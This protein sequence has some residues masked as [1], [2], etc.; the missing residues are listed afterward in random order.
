MRFALSYCHLFAA[1]IYVILG[2]MII[3][4]D[5][6]SRLNH[7]CAGIFACLFLWSF[8]YT[9]IHH[10]DVSISAVEFFERLAAPG[11]MLFSFFHLWFI[12][13]YSR[14]KP[15]RFFKITAVGTMFVP[16]LLMYQQ[17]ANNA[18]ISRHERSVFGWISPWTPS[19]W[20][21]IFFI[22]YSATVLVGLF[23]LFGHRKRTENAAIKKQTTILIISAVAS[24]TIGS[25][26]DIVLPLV[27][28]RPIFSAGDIAA[29]I[30]AV[31]LAYVVAK[32]RLLDISAINA[33]QRIISAMKDLLFLL[34]TH[35]RI[36]LVNHSTL[37]T[38]GCSNDRL[39]GT[40]FM[41]I[42]SATDTQRDNLAS[43]IVTLTASTNETALALG[44]MPPIPVLLSTSLI[45]GTGIVCVAHDMSLQKQRTHLLSEEK[46]RL[47][48]EVAL[49]TGEL[50]KT[51]EQ[52]LREI[53][54]RKQAAMSLMETEERFR[55]IYENAPDGIFLMDPE[56]NFIDGNRQSHTILGFAETG[57]KGKN[58]FS[59]GVLARPGAVP[60]ARDEA[61]PQKGLAFPWAHETTLVGKDGVAVPVEIKTHPIKIGDKNLVLGVVR[62]LTI[63]K[64]AEAEAEELKRELHQAQ[65]MEAIGRLAG[66]IAHDFN[67]LLTGITGYS[68]LLV[69]KLMH[70]HPADTLVVQ[71][72]IDIARQATN[73]T[74]QLLAFARKGKYQVTP[75]NMHDV[76]D[77][78]TGLLEHI[79]DRTI[80]VK[81]NCLAPSSTVMGDR[82]QLHSAIL[83]IA[84][85]ARDA[86][87][88]GGEISF[89][90]DVVH[91]DN[92]LAHSYPYMI[93]PGD[94]LKMTIADNGIGMDEKVRSRVFEPFF[95][96]K[97]PGKGTGLGLASVYGTVK[98]HNGFIELW[99]EPG[100]GAIFTLFLPLSNE[101]AVRRETVEP[102]AAPSGPRRGNI[103]LV[104]D[105]QMI[106]EIASDVLKEL[107][108]TVNTCCDGG[109]ALSW[110]RQFHE[111]CDLV[112]L[113]L[114]MPKLSGKEC[115]R[116]MRSI[117]PSCK[118]IIMSGHAMDSEISEL[119]KEGAIAFLQK[120]FENERLVQTVDMVLAAPRQKA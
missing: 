58:A 46:K 83:N 60:A 15:F 34:D 84:V 116:A 41:E 110:F 75:V 20:T 32:Y 100:K 33:A 1:V 67:N 51:N 90:T 117:Q 108:Y 118:T 104:D 23:L 80:S 38:L 114:T 54:D 85:N 52:L 99:S 8:S 10:P 87:P 120:P 61:S 94:F 12:W 19:I 44:A 35:G 64:K 27:M 30:W 92:K 72:I 40:P 96:T 70:S 55:L 26:I 21:T 16:L 47:E 56:G 36:M 62:D 65:K 57:L 18:L 115:F 107:G 48:S 73:R 91:I 109:E 78:V 6:R 98:H 25:T 88:D 111:Q 9:W 13:L 112:I 45:P 89:S 97:E 7:V 22:Y 103:L 3:A 74:S 68:G 5:P 4:K 102:A 43:A 86:L 59:L 11:W 24:I 63:R 49:A 119:L 101:E 71:K 105:V 95:S 29:L 106:R 42:V 31:G 79:V 81:K 2:L 77:D 37:A 39:I 69:K 50:Q 66:G 53:A 14:R 93:E 17:I 82:A 28:M 76:L 113:D